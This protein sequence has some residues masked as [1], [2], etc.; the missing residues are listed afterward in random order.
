MV[1]DIMHHFDKHQAL[2]NFQHG[3]R[4]GHSCETQLIAFIEDRA[5]EMQNGGQTDVTLG[6]TLNRVY[7]SQNPD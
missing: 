5:K 6:L 3:F 1:S 4:R 2:S 7:F